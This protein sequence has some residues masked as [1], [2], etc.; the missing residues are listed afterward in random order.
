MS[1][2]PTLAGQ[3]QNALAPLPPSHSYP[4][5]LCP[6]DE[7]FKKYTHTHTHTHTHPGLCFKL[8]PCKGG[9]WTPPPWIPSPS[10]P[11]ALSQLKP[12][13]LGTFFGDWTKFSLHFRCMSKS[14]LCLPCVLCLIDNHFPVLVGY[15]FWKGGGVMWSTYSLIFAHVYHIFLHGPLD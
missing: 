12:L 1:L 2:L 9:R 4:T 13:V 15:V 14:V 8:R 6:F 3:F 7:I 5:A 10:P 11:S